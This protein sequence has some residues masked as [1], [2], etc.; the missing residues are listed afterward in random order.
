MD[1]ESLVDSQ[2]SAVALQEGFSKNDWMTQLLKCLYGRHK[3]EY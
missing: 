2:E 1:V 3:P